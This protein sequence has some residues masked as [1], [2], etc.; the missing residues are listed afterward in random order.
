MHHHTPAAP[1]T[2]KS[3][4]KIKETI[5]TPTPN[6]HSPRK[7]ETHIRSQRRTIIECQELGRRDIAECTAHDDVELRESCSSYPSIPISPTHTNTT[8]QFGPLYGNECMKGSQVSS[9]ARIVVVVDR[10]ARH[11]SSNA[12][13]PASAKKQAKTNVV[14]IVHEYTEC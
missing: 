11:G 4:N 10:A 9:C 2:Q 13:R 7:R 6:K 3:Q 1:P 14:R 12:P 8:I 5:S